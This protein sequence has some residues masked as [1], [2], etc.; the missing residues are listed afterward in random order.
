MSGARTAY[1]VA[2]SEDR[3]AAFYTVANLGLAAST[4]RCSAFSVTSPA[5]TGSTNAI[6]CTMSGS[7]T[8]Q[9][10]TI[11]LIRTQEGTWSCS[12]TVEEKLAPATCASTFTP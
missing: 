9:G 8:V 7:G 1:D 6:S 4:S 5:A 11:T 3:A 10:G 2:V 12:T